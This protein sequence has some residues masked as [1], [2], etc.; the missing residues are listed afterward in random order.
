MFDL[1]LRPQSPILTD[2][3]YPN[4]RPNSRSRV[5]PLSDPERSA[6]QPRQD[7]WIA[8]S[9]ECTARPIESTLVRF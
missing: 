7:V 4:T 1:A 2:D 8:P 6:V 3:P 9:V 5:T